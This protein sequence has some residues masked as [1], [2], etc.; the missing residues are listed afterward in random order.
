VSHVRFEHLTSRPQ[1]PAR[2]LEHLRRLVYADHLTAPI[3]QRLEHPPAA[4][5]GLEDRSRLQFLHEPIRFV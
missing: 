1:T 4:A 3:R 5:A 2:E